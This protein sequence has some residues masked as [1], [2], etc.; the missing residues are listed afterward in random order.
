MV[1]WKKREQETLGLLESG[2][3]KEGDDLKTTYP[4]LCLSHG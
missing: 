1:S 4:V 2:E 3:K